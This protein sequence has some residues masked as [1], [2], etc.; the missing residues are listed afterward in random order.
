MALDLWLP[1][2]TPS[3]HHPV[4]LFQK[5]RYEGASWRLEKGKYRGADLPQELNLGEDPT[6]ITAHSAAVY[7]GHAI[8]LIYPSKDAT[9]LTGNVPRLPVP[10]RNTEVRVLEV[11]VRRTA[12]GERLLKEGLIDEGTLP[13]SIPYSGDSSGGFGVP[14]WALAALPILYLISS[15]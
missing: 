2:P 3:A 12:W 9:T 13:D 7:P 11:R 4:T 1:E 15:E 5:P 8:D 14:W 10:E 6:F